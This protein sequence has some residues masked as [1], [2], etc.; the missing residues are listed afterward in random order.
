MG[1]VDL[2]FLVWSWSVGVTL[3]GLALARL[4]DPALLRVVKTMC[5]VSK[6][7]VSSC[8]RTACQGTVNIASNHNPGLASHST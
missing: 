5:A 1:P 4:L 7:L 8:A 6:M 3:K 2:L